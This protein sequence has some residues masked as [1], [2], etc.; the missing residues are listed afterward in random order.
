MCDN[1]KT[2]HI[3]VQRFRLEPQIKRNSVFMYVSCLEYMETAAFNY[4]DLRE[5]MI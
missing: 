5:F 3:G 2:Q 4:S 1:V